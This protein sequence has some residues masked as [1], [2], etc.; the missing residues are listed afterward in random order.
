MKEATYEI[1][2][3]NEHDRVISQN[4]ILKIISDALKSH[5][6]TM[7]YSKLHIQAPTVKDFEPVR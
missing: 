2:F 5:P 7:G 4:T 3:V 1:T 6:L